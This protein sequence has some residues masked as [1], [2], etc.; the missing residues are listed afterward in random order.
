M[1]NKELQD[2]IEKLKN[3]KEF[4]EKISKLKSVPFRYY[5]NNPHQKK[6]EDC[7]IRA[8]AAG[9]GDSWEDTV[10]NLAEYMIKTG[11][12]INTPDLYGKYLKS[13][14]WIKQKQ[15]IYPNKKKMKVGD[16]VKQFKGKAIIHVGK[17]HVSYVSDGKIWDIWNCEDEIMGIY[18]I[19][20]EV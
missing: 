12:M 16:F 3:D 1:S 20:E 11:Y 2:A 8:I 9:T 18:W 13:I 10:R 14:G 17:T 19:P 6:T 7:V 4:Q 5:N 15:P